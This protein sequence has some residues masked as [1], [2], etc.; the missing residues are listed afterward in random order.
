MEH[1]PSALFLSEMLRDR[2]VRF[3]STLGVV[4]MHTMEGFVSWPSSFKALKRGN[5]C[6]FRPRFSYFR[7]YIDLVL[8]YSQM[9]MELKSTVV[10]V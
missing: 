9:Q 3:D 8:A 5:V 1:L 2:A 10:G 7:G 6:H 4:A